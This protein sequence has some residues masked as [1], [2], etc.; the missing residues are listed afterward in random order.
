MSDTPA[1]VQAELI[2][3]WRTLSAGDR[4]QRVAEL[5]DSCER[6]ALA[7]IRRRH[8]SAGEREVWLRLIALRLGRDVMVEVYGWDPDVEGW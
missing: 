4:F 1:V 6:P 3:R 2:E 5:N 7:G 8:P